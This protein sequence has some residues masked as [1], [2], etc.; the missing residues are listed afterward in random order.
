MLFVKKRWYI[1][2]ELGGKLDYYVKTRFPDKVR[3]IRSIRRLGLIRAR[4]LGSKNAKGDVLIFLDAH[5]EVA[6]HWYVSTN[7]LLVYSRFALTE[8]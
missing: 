2:E 4:L 3:L 6:V 7:K 5:C 8:H 1:V